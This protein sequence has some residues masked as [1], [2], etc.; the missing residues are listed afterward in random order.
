[1]IFSSTVVPLLIDNIDTDQIIPAEFLK[2]TTKDGLG[3]HLFQNWRYTTDLASKEDFPLNQER[4]KNAEIL[5]AGHNFGCG[6]SREHAAWALVDYGFKAI[7]SSGFADIFKDNAYNNQLLPIQLNAEDLSELSQKISQN[8]EL[9]I[10]IDLANQS[11]NLEEHNWFRS[12]EIDPFKKECLLN[13]T[14]ETSYLVNLRQEIEQF[15]KTLI[16]TGNE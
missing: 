5:L 12:F 16:Q 14:D 6:S 3:K 2:Q 13:G 7:V 15:E 8:P 1:M 9:E 11:L 10:T 4:Y